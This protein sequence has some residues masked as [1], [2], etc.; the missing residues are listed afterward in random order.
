MIFTYTVESLYVFRLAKSLL[1]TIRERW[2]EVKGNRW[3]LRARR[4]IYQVE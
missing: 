2:R 4:C 1:E 3:K